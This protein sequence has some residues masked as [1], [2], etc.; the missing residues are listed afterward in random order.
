MPGKLVRP[1]RQQGNALL[2]FLNLLW[3]TDDHGAK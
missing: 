3:D 2:L 1:R